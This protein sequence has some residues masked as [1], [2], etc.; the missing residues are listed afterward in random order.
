MKIIKRVFLTIW[1][2]GIALAQGNMSLQASASW[3]PLPAKLIV[4]S[5]GEEGLVFELTVPDFELQ[6]GSDG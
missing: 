2:I 3:K 1:I 6:P 5:S 4:L